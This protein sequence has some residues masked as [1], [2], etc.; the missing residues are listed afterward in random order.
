[1][2]GLSKKLLAEVLEGGEGKNQSRGPLGIPCGFK[3]RDPEKSV[4]KTTKS[5][6]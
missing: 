4:R 6:E 3:K 1:M 2:C 5:K